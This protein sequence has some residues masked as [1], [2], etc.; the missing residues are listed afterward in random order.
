[1]FRRAL[2]EDPSSAEA[3]YGLGSIY[4]KQQK[5]AEARASFERAVRLPSSYPETLPNAWN[6]LGLLATNEGRTLEA[7]LDFQEALRLSPDHLIALKNLGNAY[8]LQKQ[9]DESRAVLE[10]A[11]KDSPDDP[12]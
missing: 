7:V 11:L 4:L 1:S 6:N 2:R 8:R 9:W 3:L 10:H 5:T 12:E